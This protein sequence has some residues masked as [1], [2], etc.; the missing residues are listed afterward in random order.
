MVILASPPGFRPLHLQAA[1]AAGKHIFAEKPVAVDGPG[2]RTVM[3]ACEEAKK[4][5]LTIVSGLCWRYDTGMREAFERIHAPMGLDIGAIS[6]EEIAI[7]VTAEMI[8]VRRNAGS[9]WRAR[10]LSVFDGTERTVLSK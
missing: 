6:P 4:K 1:V 5:N 9:N 2:V 8:A 7:S 3:K 10:S